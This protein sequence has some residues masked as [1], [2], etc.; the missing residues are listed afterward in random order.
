MDIFLSCLLPFAYPQ[1]EVTVPNLQQAQQLTDVNAF[2][3]LTFQHAGTIMQNLAP[4]LQLFH[5]KFPSTSTTV[6]QQALQRRY[7]SRRLWSGQDATY[8]AGWAQSLS[9]SGTITAAAPPSPTTSAPARVHFFPSESSFQA[10]R[11]LLAFA[12]QTLD[13]CVF[14]ITDNDI[15]ASLI[16]AKKRGVRVRIVSDDEQAKS[17]GSD[18]LRL[19]NDHR[20][21]V[22]LDNRPSHMHHKFAVVDGKVVVNGS[23]NWTKK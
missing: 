22:Y 10:L 20:V 18:V 9:N 1:D 4:W 23:F 13:V 7:Q 5:Q 17:L 12:Q 16:Q 2:L 21:E 8:I 3:D 19:K 6:I 14:T 15:A 11:D